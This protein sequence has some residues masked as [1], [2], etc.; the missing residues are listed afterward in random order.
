MP[1]VPLFLGGFSDSGG[2][3]R[4]GEGG[5]DTWGAE[6]AL[7]AGWFSGERGGDRIGLSE[8][9]EGGT[10]GNDSRIESAVFDIADDPETLLLL[11][12]LCA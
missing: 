3:G 11:S 4:R 10:K 6:A 12:P 9:G 5:V 1:S 7:N 2:G 8:M